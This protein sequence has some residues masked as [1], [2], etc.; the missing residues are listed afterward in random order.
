MSIA[1]LLLRHKHIFFS[2]FKGGFGNYLLLEC[3]NFH[4]F[5]L[6]LL[7]VARDQGSTDS[8]NIFSLEIKLYIYLLNS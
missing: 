2:L 3:L 6:V 8:Q 5:L 7:K 1:V 4:W